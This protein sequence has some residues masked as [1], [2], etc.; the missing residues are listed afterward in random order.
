MFTKVFAATIGVLYA[1]T[2]WLV[3][4]GSIGVIVWKAEEAQ[5][6]APKGSHF[7][8]FWTVKTWYEDDEWRVFGVGITHGELPCHQAVTLM[9]RFYSRHRGPAH[10]TKRRYH[11]IADAY[12]IVDGWKCAEGAGGGGCSRGRAQIA[13]EF[14]ATPEEELAL[15]EWWGAIPAIGTKAP[16]AEEARLQAEEA[17][18][19]PEQ[20]APEPGKGAPP[21]P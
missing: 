1:V 18:L 20:T 6:A 19:P 9:R 4:W 17:Q 7:C 13:A 11:D 8:G 5:A 12:W 2:V 21:V 3:V 16:P 10:Y 15:E 14:V